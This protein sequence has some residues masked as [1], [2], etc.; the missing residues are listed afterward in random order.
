MEVDAYLRVWRARHPGADALL[1]D[2]PL[3]E[4]AIVGGAPS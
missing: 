1:L 4:P 2:G 3:G